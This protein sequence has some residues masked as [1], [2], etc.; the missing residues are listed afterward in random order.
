MH[1]V[2]F[3]AFHQLAQAEEGADKLGNNSGQSRRSYTPVKD[4]YKQKIQHNVY[5]GGDD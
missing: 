2:F 1:P 4:A 3:R 5:N